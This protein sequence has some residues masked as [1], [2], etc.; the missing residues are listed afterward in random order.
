MFSKLFDHK[1]FSDSCPIT[2]DQPH[3]RPIKSDFAGDGTED[4]TFNTIRQDC[5]YQLLEELDNLRWGVRWGCHKTK[6][7]FSLAGG[8]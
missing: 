8:V 7:G 1:N 3:P 2:H 4:Y 6:S 5:K